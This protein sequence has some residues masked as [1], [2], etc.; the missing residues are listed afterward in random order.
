MMRGIWQVLRRTWRQWQKMTPE[1]GQERCRN[2][3]TCRHVCSLL[4][5]QTTPTNNYA[6]AL[7]D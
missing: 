6:K 3:G 1:Y 4:K 2:C 7:E 5:A